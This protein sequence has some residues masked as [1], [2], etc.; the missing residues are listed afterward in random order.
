MFGE[1]EDGELCY[2]KEDTIRVQTN[3]VN[4][5][6]EEEEEVV[7]EDESTK[8]KVERFNV[9]DMEEAY[10]DMTFIIV[11]FFISCVSVVGI[12]FLLI[13]LTYKLIKSRS[14]CELE[15]LVSPS[16]CRQSSA[17]TSVPPAK[18]A[19]TPVVKKPC[20]SLRT[21]SIVKELGRGYYSKVYLAQHL[22]N[23]FVALKTVDNQKTTNAEECISNEI[24]ILT[25]VGPHLNIVKLLGFNREEKLLVMEYAFNGNLKDY[26]SR[27]RDYYMDE[28][29][30]ETGELK[31][32]TF[33]YKSPTDSDSFPMS[34]FLTSMHA[35]IEQQDPEVARRN[36]EVP[37]VVQSKSLIKTRRLLY[38][39]YQV[40]KGMKYLA[41]L[42]I[43][44]R[45][46]ALRNM[47]LTNND[48]V[49]IADFGLAVRYGVVSTEWFPR[50]IE[51]HCLAVYSPGAALATLV[52]WRL[53]RCPSTG[54]G[55]TSR[56]PT[57]GW[58]WRVS[59]PT[60][61]PRALTSGPSL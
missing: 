44:H 9:G 39:S 41:D 45:D 54:A 16:L 51:I 25:T 26:I 46:V 36:K 12:C 61:T 5:E 34:D 56:S 42:G 33:L 18:P 15:E 57:S 27:Y 24:D 21:T 4:T 19:S 52:V 47:L 35:D 13:L 3:N 48:V 2:K 14:K 20:W 53:G 37:V 17:P 31:E 8:V 10:F 40:S 28:I 38:W 32:E 22:K 11:I 43:I 59:S 6:E 7:G 49:K 60:C 50:H 1:D 55:A 23:G 58:R 29:N 30:P